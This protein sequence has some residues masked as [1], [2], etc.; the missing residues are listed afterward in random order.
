MTMVAPIDLAAIKDDLGIAADDTAHD[1]WLERR[2]DGLW[3][4]FQNYTARPLALAGGWVDDWGELVFPQRAEPLPPAIAPPPR[5]PVFLRVYPV[6]QISRITIG[7]SDGDASKVLFDPPSGKL[8]GIDGR[9]QDL[10]EWMLSSRIRIEYNA[11]FPAVPAD[12]YEALLGG[13]GPQWQMRQALTS[14]LAVGGLMPTR[15]NAVDVGETD[16]APSANFFV[17]RASRS[18]VADPLLGPWTKLLEIYV[19]HRALIGAPM[20]T[21]RALPAPPP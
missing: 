11:G 19:D 12:L 10:G 1:A 2:V 4:R 15:I 6:S 21:T 14:G 18:G 16:L 3:A 17:D 5:G 9:A 20:P 8:L 13:L 7:G